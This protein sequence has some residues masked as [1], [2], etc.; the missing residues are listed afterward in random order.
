MKIRCE[1][2]YKKIKDAPKAEKII[3]ILKS[4]G[5]KKDGPELHIEGLNLHVIYM[6]R[7]IKDEKL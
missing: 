2:K 5:W 3:S 6:K 4:E 7:I 1:I